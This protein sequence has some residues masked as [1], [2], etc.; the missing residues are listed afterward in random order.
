MTDYLANYGTNHREKSVR[1]AKQRLAHVQRLLASCLLCDLHEAKIQWYIRT[2]LSE[3][4][5]GRTINM[6]VGELSRAMK[7]KWSIAWPN[8]RKLEERKDVGQALSPEQEAKLIEAAKES[9]SPI[10]STFIRVALFTGM[11]SGE[12]ASLTWGQ[13]DLI[14]RVLRVGRAK[15]SSGTGRTIPMNEELFQLLKIHANWF[16]ERFGELLPERFL[17]PYGTPS[18]SDPTRPTTTMKTAWGGLRKRAGVS[19]RLHDLRHTAATK[20]AE[21]GVPESTMLSIMGH[22]SRAMIE[23]YSHVRM[24]AK[25]SAVEAL[26]TPKKAPVSNEVPKESPKVEHSPQVQ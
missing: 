14:D 26:S 6:E 19:C 16:G 8:V 4:V 23:R 22:M 12:I 5:G 17:F 13:V 25:R 18:P 10:I 24:A 2:R 11:R 21:A 7:I 15:T 9:H 3:G 20:M 1:F